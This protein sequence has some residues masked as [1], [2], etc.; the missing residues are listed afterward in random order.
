MKIFM[1]KAFTFPFVILTLLVSPFVF[2]FALM[3]IPVNYTL[4]FEPKGSIVQAFDKDCNL[5]PEAEQSLSRLQLFEIN[6]AESKSPLQETQILWEPVM[7]GSPKIF[8]KGTADFTLMRGKN[9]WVYNDAATPIDI[10]GHE[11]G[12]GKMYINL[13]YNIEKEAVLNL[14]V[15]DLASRV[16]QKLSPTSNC[17]F[18]SNINVDE[19]SKTCSPSGYFSQLGIGTTFVFTGRAT[20]LVAKPFISS[21]NDWS[22]SESNSN[23]DGKPTITCH[24]KVTFTIPF[25]PDGYSVSANRWGSVFFSKAELDTAE[26]NFK[27]TNS[28]KELKKE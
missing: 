6:Q 3:A 14:D 20:G 26:W 19:E 21:G 11:I 16:C 22:Y 7:R 4:I 25:D 8:C 10:W 2:Y 5:L 17:G 24:M 1:R 27:I 9:Y 12:G 18:V 15:S 13:D 28:I 23:F